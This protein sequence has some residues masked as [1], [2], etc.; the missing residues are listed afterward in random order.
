MSVAWSA[1]AVIPQFALAKSPSWLASFSSAISRLLLC[2]WLLW[3]LAPE[4]ALAL[5]LPPTPLVG[6]A[7]QLTPEPPPDL[8]KLFH[9]DAVPEPAFTP[10]IRI[11]TPIGK[12]WPGSSAADVVMCTVSVAVFD[13]PWDKVSV[14]PD[15]LL[16]VVFAGMSGPV[17]A[18]PARTVEGKF[19]PAARVAVVEVAVSDTPR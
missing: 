19:S 5:K 17:M 8:A 4:A 12:P 9:V 3:G 6:P 13:A 11:G 7:P 16:T 14:P 18:S 1:A 15:T 10:M 2:P